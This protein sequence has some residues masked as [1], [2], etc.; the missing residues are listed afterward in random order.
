MPVN[1]QLAKIYNIVNTINDTIY[2]GSTAQKLLSSR[3]TCHR[4]LATEPDRTS[5]LYEAMRKLGVDNFRIVLV[6]A[7]PCNSKDELEAE[8]YR[9]MTAAIK[10]GKSVYNMRIAPAGTIK[11][12]NE[13]KAKLAKALVGRFRGD[14]SNHFKCGSLAYRASV[15]QWNFEWYEDAKKKTK[16]Y[17]E[18]TWGMAAKT[19]IQVFR[20]T[21]Y[22]S[23]ESEETL[24]FDFGNIDLN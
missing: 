19:M 23:F 17:S 12:T 7:F 16:S 10:A 1:Y 5:R 3:M 4:R 22:P 18:K 11:M 21:I 15:R 8:E 6:H 13:T 20:R 24:V 14:E 2:F 9:V